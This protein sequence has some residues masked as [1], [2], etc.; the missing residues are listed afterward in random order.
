M[1]EKIGFSETIWIRK[2]RSI[3]FTERKSY[4]EYYT[5]LKYISKTEFQIVL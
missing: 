4:L 5:Q 1:E 2:P 3:I